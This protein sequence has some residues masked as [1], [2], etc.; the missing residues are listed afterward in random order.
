M[1][2][3]NCDSAGLAAIRA[4]ITAFWGSDRTLYLH[5]PMLVYEFG[6]TAF[7]IRHEGKIAAYL[8]GFFSQVENV[9]YVHLVAVRENYKRQGLGKKLYDHF[10]AV[11]VA[12]DVKRLKAITSTDNLR[13][14]AFHT[15]QIGMQMQGE[16][17]ESGIRIVKD[18][19]GPGQD[20]V[21]FEKEIGFE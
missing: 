19:S 4:E 13:S 7:V 21:V 1:E 11:A 20:R 17:T 10:I 16:L 5:H 3:T 15:Q 12:H 8:F 6:N 18:Y 14:V 9:A 2:I